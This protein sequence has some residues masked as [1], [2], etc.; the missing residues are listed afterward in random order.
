MPS[1]ALGSAASSPSLGPARRKVLV[2]I[3]ETR[4]L[5]T[6]LDEARRLAALSPLASAAKCMVHVGLTQL[7]AACSV[8]TTTAGACIGGVGSEARGSGVLEL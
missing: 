7:P 5:R 8:A 2:L 1:D 3:F 4:A 6:D